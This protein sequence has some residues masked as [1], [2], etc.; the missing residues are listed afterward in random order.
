MK[1]SSKGLGV[2]RLFEGLALKAYPDP[3]SKNGDPWT[4][5]YG[6]TIGVKPG[7]TCKES[8]AEEWLA[9]DVSRFERAVEKLVKVPLTQPQFDAL[10][11]FCFNVG[12]GNLA[13]STLL[14][15]LN[16]GAYADVPAQLKR[17]DKAG[18]KVMKGLVRRRAA[19]A[20]LWS[21]TSP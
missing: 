13:K 21:S 8:H 7:M 1:T 16:A 17:W 14:R 5:G 20:D 6:H 3:G 18:G 9:W 2:I 11:S 12:E 4:I 19:E 10:I 15:R